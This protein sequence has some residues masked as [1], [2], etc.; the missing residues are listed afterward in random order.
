[1]G[2]VRVDVQAARAKPGFVGGWLGPEGIIKIRNWLSCYNKFVN[3]NAMPSNKTKETYKSTFKSSLS[4]G[5]IIVFRL[6]GIVYIFSAYYL[7]SHIGA[8]LNLYLGEFARSASQ[9]FIAIVLMIGISLIVSPG[10]FYR[11]AA[12]PFY[13]A[14]GSMF[15]YV[16]LKFA[17]PAALSFILALFELYVFLLVI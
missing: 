15:I 16:I 3:H 17:L 13:I 5:M 14:F 6:Y 2:G 8:A 9:I 11:I 12:S 4:P 10:K 1:M 7:Y